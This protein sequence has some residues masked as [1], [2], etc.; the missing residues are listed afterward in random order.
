M[1]LVREENVTKR[2]IARVVSFDEESLALVLTIGVL[3]YAR[4]DVTADGAA[5]AVPQR[6]LESLFGA[7]LLRDIGVAHP[8][9]P[10]RAGSPAPGTRSAAVLCCHRRSWRARGGRS[11]RAAAGRL[12]A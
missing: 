11:H 3:G 6:L 9:R 7:G 4:A 12:R 1:H 5:A 2:S 8:R 10:A